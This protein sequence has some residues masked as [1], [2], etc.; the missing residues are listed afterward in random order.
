MDDGRQ[1]L[2]R[3]RMVAGA[4]T[5]GALAAAVAVLPVSRQPAGEAATAQPAAPPS[6][7]YRLSEHVLQYYQTT[8]I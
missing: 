8:R 5:A 2:T 4:G 6:D 3:R 7:G 1:K